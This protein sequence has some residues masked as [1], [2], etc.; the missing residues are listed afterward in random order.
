MWIRDLSILCSSSSEKVFE[1]LLRYVIQTGKPTQSQVPIEKTNPFYIALPE[2]LLLILTTE[3]STPNG[4]NLKLRIQPYNL[5]DEMDQKQV[6]NTFPERLIHYL[7]EKQPEWE[8]T[9]HPLS[10]P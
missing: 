5:P 8:L 3:T 7:D 2:E 4:A 9:L 1:I 10:H 6:L